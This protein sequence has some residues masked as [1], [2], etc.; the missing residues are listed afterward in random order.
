MNNRQKNVAKIAKQKIQ[1]NTKKIEDV[2][3]GLMAEEFFKKKN[4]KWNA[5][6]IAEYVNLDPRTV[7]KYLKLNVKKIA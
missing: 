3:N 1:R 7:S 5:R 2:I 6:A 4:G